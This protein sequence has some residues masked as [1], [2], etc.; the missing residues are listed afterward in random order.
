MDAMPLYPCRSCGPERIIVN[1]TALR[2]CGIPES[3]WMKSLHHGCSASHVIGVGM[4]EDETHHAS[5]P[6]HHIRNDRRPTCVSTLPHSA[7]IKDDPSPTIGTE[8]NRVALPDIQN[9]QLDVA[10]IR[11]MKSGTPR[12]ETKRARSDNDRTHRVTAHRRDE[13]RENHR[14]ARDDGEQG[15]HDIDRSAWY[16]GSNRGHSVEQ[17]EQWVTSSG[18]ECTE[19]RNRRSD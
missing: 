5:S 16:R 14:T 6:P 11:K 17:E 12:D 18:E 13:Q 8:E 9:V 10:A 7:G 15:R 2:K 1:D 4:R 19:S 3:R